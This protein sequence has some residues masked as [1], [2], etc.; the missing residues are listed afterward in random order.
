MAFV[1]AICSKCGANISVNNQEDAGICQYCGTAFVTQK[2]IN[3]YIQYN[4]NISNNYNQTNNIN[5]Y[6]NA[7]SINSVLDLA[8]NYVDTMD[9]NNALKYCDQALSMDS[10]AIQ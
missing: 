7:Y 3:N 4:Q 9:V 5:I 6:N 1:P 8:Q 2:V 10:I